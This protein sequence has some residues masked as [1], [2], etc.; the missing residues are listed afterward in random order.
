MSTA[1]TLTLHCAVRLQGGELDKA[2]APDHKLFS[3]PETSLDP[4]STATGGSV[5]PV[6]KQLSS[7]MGAGSSA[8]MSLTASGRWAPQL[9]SAEPAAAANATATH[10][11]TAQ[12]INSSDAVTASSE[13]EDLP[14][15]PY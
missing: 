14:L 2:D 1:G 5:E 15:Q 4:P 11:P 7:R 6:A 13:P 9:Q 8:G 12:M 3:Q 10:Q